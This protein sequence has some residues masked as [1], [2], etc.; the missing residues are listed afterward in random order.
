MSALATQG[1]QSAQIQLA[2]LLRKDGDIEGFKQWLF[3]V[4]KEN[5]DFAQRMLIGY[6]LFDP[7]P[8]FELDIV[9]LH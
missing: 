6:Y 1:R 2:L 8:A 5:N 4:A 9:G 3:A 7:D